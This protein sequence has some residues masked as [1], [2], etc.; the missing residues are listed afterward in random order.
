MFEIY[1]LHEVHLLLYLDTV[2]NDGLYVMYLYVKLLC[3]YIHRVSSDPPSVVDERSFRMEG[4]DTDRLLEIPHSPV[5]RERKPLQ[6][7]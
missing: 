7:E 1:L 2:C 4:E 5:G 6:G 3:I